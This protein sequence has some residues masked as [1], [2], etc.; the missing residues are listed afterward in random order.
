MKMQGQ[1]TAWQRE[2]LLSISTLRNP[3][4]IRK[5]LL[6]MPQPETGSISPEKI[7]A[8]EIHPAVTGIYFTPAGGRQSLQEF[9][10]RYGDALRSHL[11]V[12][13][14][15]FGDDGNR[16]GA[17]LRNR[18]MNGNRESSCAEGFANPKWMY[19]VESQI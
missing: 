8:R 12:A 7:P 6:E 15:W 19:A 4:E 11:M 1:P 13:V 2:K 18:L 16:H 10:H 17:I 9:R 5:Q 3:H 14:A